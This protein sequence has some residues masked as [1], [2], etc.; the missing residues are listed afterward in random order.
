MLR[1]E[2]QPIAKLLNTRA[3]RAFKRSKSDEDDDWLPSDQQPKVKL[4]KV[5]RNREKSKRTSSTKQDLVHIDDHQ[6]LANLTRSQKELESS[7]ELL[8][9][10][11]HSAF[12]LKSEVEDEAHSI[13]A[14]CPQPV[15]DNQSDVED[16]R[17]DFGEDLRYESDSSDNQG[18]DKIV[19][20]DNKRQ[21]K[22]ETTE[23]ELY[24][25]GHQYAGFP[26]EMMKGNTPLF[27]L[28]ELRD[29]FSR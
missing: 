8:R 11:A 15:D 25:E 28:A 3:S 2:S 10:D 13:K 9:S 7:D 5:K 20:N 27:S 24:E 12:P 29:W 23:V 18:N 21:A 26:K 4:C 1:I 16:P 19:R 14:E 22:V 6:P 17:D